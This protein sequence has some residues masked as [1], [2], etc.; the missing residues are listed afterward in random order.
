MI[1]ENV[2]LGLGSNMGDR[3]AMLESA[4]EHLE[5]VEGLSVVSKSTIIETEPLE[6]M[7]QRNYLNMVVKVVTSLN[8]SVLLSICLE[9]EQQHGRTRGKK[10][11]SRTIDIDILFYGD[12]QIKENGLTIPHPEAHVRRFVLGPLAEIAPDFEH[13][14]KKIQIVA[15]LHAL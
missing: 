3:S 10:W 7:P 9:I 14:A 8:P 13:P 1:Q 12:L 2:F 6:N 11:A 4:V 5:R 15:M